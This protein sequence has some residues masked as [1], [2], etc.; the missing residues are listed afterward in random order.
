MVFEV[1]ADGWVRHCQVRTDARGDRETLTEPGH[2]CFSP[3]MTPTWQLAVLLTVFSAALLSS[4]AGKSLQKDVFVPH[5]EGEDHKLDVSEHGS[6]YTLCN[7]Q[8]VTTNTCNLHYTKFMKFKITVNL[9]KSIP[10][11]LLKC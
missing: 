8:R 1:A 3:N 5:Y 10:K 7:M 9:L 11:E 4:A 6:P 2:L